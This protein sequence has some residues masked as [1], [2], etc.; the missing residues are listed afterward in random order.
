MN[1]IN[2]RRRM[3]V[4]EPVRQPR[5]E[6]GSCDQSH[7]DAGED[8]PWGD[9]VLAPVDPGGRNRQRHGQQREAHH[10]RQPLRDL[11]PGAQSHGDRQS[12]ADAK[13]A[14]REARDRANGDQSGGRNR[15]GRWRVAAL[16]VAARRPCDHERAERGQIEDI[17]PLQEDPRRGDGDPRARRAA[18]EEA[19]AEQDEPGERGAVTFPP[20]AAD[21][22]EAGRE[23][24][25]DKRYA[26]R[27]VLLGAEQEN[28]KHDQAAPRADPEQ[29]RGE[30][31]GQS[32]RDATEKII[33]VQQLSSNLLAPVGLRAH[34][35]PLRRAFGTHDRRLVPGFGRRDHLPAH[36]GR[37]RAAVRRLRRLRLSIS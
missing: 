2:R 37:R 26:L 5:A 21:A 6:V 33:G 29:P 11:E 30:A 34:E 18:D 9:P 32:D 8:R 31:A 13:E 16:G 24:L 20:I 35:P 23:D 15:R 14:G 10:L 12:S 1:P 17:G 19:Q 25:S 27:R 3:L 36:Q 22:G 4:A 28:G 7:D